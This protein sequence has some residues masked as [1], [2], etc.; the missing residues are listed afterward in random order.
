MGGERGSW[1]SQ[2]YLSESECNNAT[3][4][5]TCS[6]QSC[7]HHD[8]HYPIAGGGKCSIFLPRHWTWIRN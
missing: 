4:I 8:S 5:E 6:R 2:S 1:L 7:S 3:G